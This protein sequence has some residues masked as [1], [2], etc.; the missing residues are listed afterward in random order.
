MGQDV[1]AHVAYGIDLEYDDPFEGHPGVEDLEDLLAATAGLVSPS[2]Q[3]PRKVSGGYGTDAYESYKQWIRDNLP[4]YEEENDTYRAAK[5]K[6]VD[7]CPVDI[8]HYGSESEWGHV[9]F[10]KG[11]M[12]RGGWEGVTEV[13]PPDLVVDG[14]KRLE[15][16]RF[17]EE[18]D[19]P[20]FENPRW[21]LYGRLW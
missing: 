7:S 19:L 10:L 2:T 11:T 13:C 16:V 18:F 3:I 1:N 21:L 6:L 15:A 12:I 14:E 8:D 17:C 20:A 9:L 4:N 5:K